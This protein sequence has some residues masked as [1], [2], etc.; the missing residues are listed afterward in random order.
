MKTLGNTALLLLITLVSCTERIE[1][2]TSDA[3][4][5]LSVFGYITNRVAT[6]T[7]TITRTAGYF[8]TQP[9]EG[10]NNAAVTLSDGNITHLLARK[11]DAAG[12]YCT[13]PNFYGT[14]N[15]TYTLNITL[16]FDNDGT[17]E[18]YTAQAHM[19][20]A[21]RVDSI[22]LQP[23]VMPRIPNLLLYGEVPDYQKNCLAVYLSKN[24]EHENIFEYLLI[25]T[26]SYFNGHIINGYA[27]PCFVD[28][29]VKKSDTILFRV[30]SFS[31]DF[32]A[33]ISN[34]RGETGGSNP[35][36]DGPPVDVQTNI[37]AVDKN[38]T[39][40]IAGYFGAF[41][42]DEKITVSDRDF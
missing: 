28:E 3:A 29:G 25:L 14:E 35:I 33:F 31:S 5:R 36:F 15:T 4:P 1:I 20:G 23:S 6:H 37:T 41:A 30:N 13:A 32:A 10:I 16:D 22:K 24:N 38:N 42:W 19:P 11:P 26:D 8:S 34:A 27:F 17:P 21:T 7:I 12:V 39:T 2:N 18:Q 9:P 40:G